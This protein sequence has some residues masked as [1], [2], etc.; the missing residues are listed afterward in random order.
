M[1]QSGFKM[2]IRC[3][4]EAILRTIFCLLLIIQSLEVQALP[5]L[6]LLAG[7]A[8]NAG[9]ARAAYLCLIRVA[10]G[11]TPRCFPVRLHSHSR[12]LST[13]PSDGHSHA[14]EPTAVA[15]GERIRSLSN[16]PLPREV[17]PC[18]QQRAMQLFSAGAGSQAVYDTNF[19]LS[20]DSLFQALSVLQGVASTN[21]LQQLAQS[22]GGACHHP[23]STASTEENTESGQADI[24]HMTNYLLF[25]C[26]FQLQNSFLTGQIPE[27]NAVLYADINF[28]DALD[29]QNL[30]ANI[31]QHISSLSNCMITNLCNPE[32]W[33]PDTALSIV[34]AIYFNGLWREPFSVRS[35]VFTLANG[36]QVSL[37]RVLH[38][39]AWH[40]QYSIEQDWQAVTISYTSGHEIIFILPPEGQMP[41][42]VTPEIVT[43]LL[44]SGWPQPVEM[45]VPAF[46][47][48]SDVQLVGDMFTQAGLDRPSWGRSWLD[49][50]LFGTRPP[51]HW[52]RSRPQRMLFG[53]TPPVSRVTQ[54]CVTDVN[55][56]GIEPTCSTIM[57]EIKTLPITV[58]FNRPFLFILRD[59]RSGRILYIGQIFHPQMEF[60][61]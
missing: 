13:R 56:R 7:V 48:E 49:L 19:V 9:S 10:P 57:T 20:P 40:T 14:G 47:I 21:S 2:N 43:E 22:L 5:N 53:S 26:D 28:C 11:Q 46:N 8:Q 38:G 44:S 37:P 1:Q 55:G 51:V 23:S 17:W 52:G 41:N 58:H 24:Y 54:R 50:L 39:L 45:S 18:Y 29:L 30:A 15:R 35:G 32:Q 42:Q 60:S 12:M 33:D 6:L 16:Q 31:N 61:P 25:S 34:S 4:F 27:M 36:Q 59:P 3:K